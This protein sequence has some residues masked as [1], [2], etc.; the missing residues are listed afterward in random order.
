MADG[1]G[2]LIECT[3]FSGTARSCS[4]LHHMYPSEIAD[5]VHRMLAKEKV[6]RQTMKEAAEELGETP[7]RN[8]PETRYLSALSLRWT[9]TPDETKVLPRGSQAS[10]IG[11][12]IGQRI[13]KPARSSS[14]IVLGVQPSLSWGWR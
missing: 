11:R 12:S 7:C 4:A 1:P 10:T 14:G 8:R 2:R 9:P 3:C 13:Q 5:L 6:Q